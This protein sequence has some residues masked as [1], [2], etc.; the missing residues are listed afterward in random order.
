MEGLVRLY[1]GMEMML[2]MVSSHQSH[3]VVRLENVGKNFGVK[4][5][6]L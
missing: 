2:Y 3:N 5:Q 1:S 6:S 4:I